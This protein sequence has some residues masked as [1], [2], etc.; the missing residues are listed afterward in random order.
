[1]PE[2]FE[3]RVSFRPG[4]NYLHETGPKARGQHGMEIHFTLLGEAGA[5]DVGFNTGWTPL[6][7]VDKDRKLCGRDPA[8]HCD[9]KDPWGFGTISPP[10]GICVS[11]HRPTPFLWDP[12]A[13]DLQEG[14]CDHLPSGRCHC[15]LSYL[16]S[17]PILKAFIE[18][19]EEPVWEAL[20]GWYRTH[21]LDLDEEPTEEES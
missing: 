5:I 6:G 18:G 15:D 16:A 20:E 13:E 3:K 11:I 4:Y 21:L 19:G 2:E 7:E 17:D 14:E 9:Y 8:V 1:M 10:S 12:G